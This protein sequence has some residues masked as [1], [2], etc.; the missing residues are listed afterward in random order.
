[1]YQYILYT[2][3]IYAKCTNQYSIHV[4]F[5]CP[6]AEEARY[7][8]GMNDIINYM[9]PELRYFTLV[10]IFLHLKS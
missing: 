8:R 7:A 9:G 5:L 1:M 2:F 6:Q 4:N 3:K 10:E